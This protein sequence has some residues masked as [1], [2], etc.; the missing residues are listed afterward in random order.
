VAFGWA[1]AFGTLYSLLMALASWVVY[2]IAFWSEN[3]EP[4]V[5]RS[6]DWLA[7]V[8]IAMCVGAVVFFIG[9]MT[10][11]LWLV[12][13]ALLVSGGAGVAAV[14]YALVEVSDHGDGKLMAYAL[15]CGLASALAVALTAIAVREQVG[16]T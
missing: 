14:W 7:F 6:N 9:V 1:V 5:A 12:V 11:R 2:V 4:D 10:V 3:V 13:P 8:A 16:A 15:A